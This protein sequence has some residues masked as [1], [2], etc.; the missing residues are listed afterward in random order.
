MMQTCASLPGSRECSS[1]A[2]PPAWLVF[3]RA[4]IPLRRARCMRCIN[5]LGAI[6]LYCFFVFAAAR[7]SS[8]CLLQA[9]HVDTQL[10]F[11]ACTSSVMAVSNVLLTGQPNLLVWLHLGPACQVDGRQHCHCS[12]SGCL[13]S[14]WHFPADSG[15]NSRSL[16]SLQGCFKGFAQLGPF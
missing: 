8:N 2:M 4:L 13:C 3:G 12:R 1:L 11:D 16:V 6:H 14:S 15:C 5:L 9:L 7:R 10:L